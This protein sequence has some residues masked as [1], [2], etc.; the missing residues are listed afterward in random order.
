MRKF[1]KNKKLITLVTVLIIVVSGVSFVLIKASIDRSA[2]NTEKVLGETISQP[3][4]ET[5]EILTGE[6][7]QESTEDNSN[8][9][10]SEV[11]PQSTQTESTNTVQISESKC[12]NP[13][14]KAVIL[15]DYYYDYHLGDKAGLFRGSYE[16]N[17]LLPE[18][19]SYEWYIWGGGAGVDLPKTLF[20]TT[21]KPDFT[22]VKK[23]WVFNILYVVKAN[24][25]GLRSEVKTWGFTLPSRE[26]EPVSYP[27]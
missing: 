18:E 22:N 2:N 23:D 14:L 7:T 9:E 10:T 16:T 27:N 5:G 11:K 12:E 13:T 25:Q 3:V 26:P 4:V 1:F 17:C 8:V 19:I 6:S 15:R 20:S 21:A 24:E